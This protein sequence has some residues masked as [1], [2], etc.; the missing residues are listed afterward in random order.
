MLTVSHFLK[1]IMAR[2]SP[3]VVTLD[4]SRHTDREDRIRRL[5]DRLNNLKSAKVSFEANLEQMIVRQATAQKDRAAKCAT[6]KLEDF[7]LRLEIMAQRKKMN[8]KLERRSYQ[9]REAQS[10]LDT[11]IEDGRYVTQIERL[12]R[13]IDLLKSEMNQELSE[14][15][16]MNQSYEAAQVRVRNQATQIR[17][18]AIDQFKKDNDERNQLEDTFFRGCVHISKTE[19]IL[20]NLKKEHNDRSMIACKSYYDKPPFIFT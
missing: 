20:A 14:R 4:E 10:S 6:L 13:E 8:E 9:I 5:Q 11:L 18:A 17:R 12:E 1:Q 16:I 7:A 19:H 15:S 3:D 2:K